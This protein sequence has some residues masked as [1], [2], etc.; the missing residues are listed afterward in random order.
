MIMTSLDSVS[1]VMTSL[2]ITVLESVSNKQALDKQ[3]MAAQL[4]LKKRFQIAARYEVWG[5]I[6]QVQRWFKGTFGRNESLKKDTIYRCHKKLV[7]GGSVENKKRPKDLPKKR[8]EENIGCHGPQPL[9]HPATAT[10]P[11]KQ[12]LPA[13]PQKV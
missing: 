1:L 11:T 10:S 2:V 3:V 6:T 4:S 12:H 9:G 7:E 13:T 8:T 5:S